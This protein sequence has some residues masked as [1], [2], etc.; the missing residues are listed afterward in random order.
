MAGGKRKRRLHHR[1]LNVRSCF[2]R[3]VNAPSIEDGVESTAHGSVGDVSQ[4]EIGIELICANGFSVINYATKLFC[5][6]LC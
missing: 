6:F 2:G 5:F 1:Q 4:S 3:P